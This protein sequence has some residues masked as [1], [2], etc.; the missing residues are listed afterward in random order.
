MKKIPVSSRFSKLFLRFSLLF[1]LLVIGGGG[2]FS[3]ENNIP[4]HLWYPSNNFYKTYFTKL[5]FN[6]GAFV[7][8]M[9]YTEGYGSSVK[10]P[11]LKLTVKEPG[12]MG[13]GKSSRSM[14]TEFLEKN[15]PGIS[16]KKA[17]EIVS[18]YIQE[19]DKEGVNY[20]VAFSQMCLETGFLRYGGSVKPQQNNF[21]G[22]GVSSN[23]S[24]GLSF[25]SI[26]IGIRAHIQH[27]KA[28]ATTARIKNP[29]VDSRLRFVKRGSVKTIGELSGKWASDKHYSTKILSLMTRLYAER[30]N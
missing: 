10:H 6:S 20:D 12:I 25:P 27:L 24:H 5:R 29:I 30:R 21:C 14:L 3:E 9:L 17:R 1:A 11:M 16:V 26:R 23:D 15:N 18:I 28:Y 22:L 8:K 2:I 7:P 4:S 13:T 19:A